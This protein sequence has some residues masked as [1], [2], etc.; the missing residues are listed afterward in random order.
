M[1]IAQHDIPQGSLPGSPIQIP[2]LSQLQ[3][4]RLTLVGNLPQALRIILQTS[5]RQR[6]HLNLLQNRHE[7]MIIQ[8]M[9]ATMMGIIA[10]M[11]IIGR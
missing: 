1:T 2:L 7:L 5:R 9:I 4:Q 3:G 11:E 10:T 6:L 8:T